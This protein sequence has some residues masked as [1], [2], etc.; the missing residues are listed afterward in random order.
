MSDK[1]IIEVR[2]IPADPREQGYDTRIEVDG[3]YGQGKDTKK[4][5]GRERNEADVSAL[6]GILVRAQYLLGLLGAFPK[7]TYIKT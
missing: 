5:D 1:G 2:V 4:L 6:V 3:E 7:D